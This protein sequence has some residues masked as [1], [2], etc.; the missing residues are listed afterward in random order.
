M[1]RRGLVFDCQGWIGSEIDI[2]IAAQRDFSLLL[3][4]IVMLFQK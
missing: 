2:K 4:T 3:Y 1:S